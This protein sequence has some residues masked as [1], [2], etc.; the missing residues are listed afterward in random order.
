MHVRAKSLKLDDGEK[1]KGKPFRGGKSARIQF[2]PRIMSLPSNFSNAS[3]YISLICEGRRFKGGN[4]QRKF[5]Y[6]FFSHLDFD[7]FL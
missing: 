2:R 7:L 1:K 5:L 4:F 3:F 6:I